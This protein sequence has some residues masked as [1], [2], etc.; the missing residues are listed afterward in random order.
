MDVLI[1]PA[2]LAIMV[3]P[4]A[5]VD[6]DIPFILT[7]I[8]VI[9]SFGVAGVGGGATASIL[10]LSTLNLPVALAG[11]LISI[12][13]IDMGR[14]ALNVNDSILAGTGTARLTGNLDKEKFNSNHYG[15]L[16]TES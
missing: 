11:V 13:P 3:A 7:L 4:V 12:E 9:S 8:V 15:E 1:Y 5:H 2:M 16:S 6:I 14:T 10:V